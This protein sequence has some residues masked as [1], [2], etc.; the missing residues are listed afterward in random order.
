MPW[1]KKL[2]WHWLQAQTNMRL[3]LLFTKSSTLNLVTPSLCKFKNYCILTYKITNICGIGAWFL[4][5]KSISCGLILSL[6]HTLSH[7]H[8]QIIYLSLALSISQSL[9]SAADLFVTR[10]V[11]IIALHFKVCIFMSCQNGVSA[12]V[13]FSSLWVVQTEGK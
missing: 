13:L 11:I 9:W 8:T 10:D 7:S 4:L 6:S 3:N 2:Y 1:P 12:T 5:L